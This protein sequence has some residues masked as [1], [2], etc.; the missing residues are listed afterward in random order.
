MT[1]GDDL[2]DP[3]ILTWGGIDD[4][5][6]VGADPSA[7]TLAEG[8]RSEA[9]GSVAAQDRSWWFKLP[10]DEMGRR[11]HLTLVG[12]GASA[13]Q[14]VMRLFWWYPPGDTPNYT[15]IHEAYGG[16]APNDTSDPTVWN[17]SDALDAG[18][19]WYIQVSLPEGNT[20]G[21]SLALAAVNPAYVPPSPNFTVNAP[22]AEAHGYPHSPDVEIQGPQ[23]FT[24]YAPRASTHSFL[25]D[26]DV[27]IEDA[28][29][30]VVIRPT[31]ASASATAPG[32]TI[33]STYTP[34]AAHRHRWRLRDPSTGELWEFPHNPNKMTSPHRPRSI[35]IFVT[36]PLY[37]PAVE[38]R[39]GM[40]RVYEHNAAPYEWTFSGWIRD[41]EQYDQLI[42]WTRKVHRVQLVDHFNRVWWIRFKEFDPDEKRPSHRSD[43]KFDYEV[44]ATMYGTA[45]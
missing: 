13:G 45:A 16:W 27:E 44:K 33:T 42:Y 37:D 9:L 35:D 23:G 39:G 8:E 43:W 30:G 25:T 17:L 28:P 36:P 18:Y 14:W 26:A 41:Q 38:A 3:F 34:D 15:D 31:R 10:S 4:A 40:T 20:A 11:T 6:S 22:R 12:D 7:C 2:L 32:P 29:G 21:S 19:D 24:V 5:V 1:H